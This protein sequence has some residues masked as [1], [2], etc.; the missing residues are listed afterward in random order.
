MCG[1]SVL[2]TFLVVLTYLAAYAVDPLILYMA[3]M[4][5]L[6]PKYNK[7]FLNIICC[8]GIFYLLIVCKQG[9]FL[10]SRSN[11]GGMI[12]PLL[13]GYLL[14][15][16]FTM[17]QAS[18][19]RIIAVVIS[20]YTLAFAVEAV[21]S[22][23]FVVVNVKMEQV[24][25]FGLKGALLTLIMRFTD[26][27][28][29]LFIKKF[30]EW[31]TEKGTKLYMIMAYSSL[32]TVAGVALTYYKGL[33]DT[34]MLFYLY[35]AQACIIIVCI[36]YFVIIFQNAID[37]E[38]E[39]IKKAELSE[40]KL[41]FLEYSKENYEEIRSIRHDMK[42]HYTYLLELNRRKDFQAIEN[43]LTELCSQL[44]V[45]DELYI[46]DNLILAVALSEAQ[47]KAKKVKI[48]FTKVVT[49]NEFPF[50]EIECNSLITNILDNAFEAAS[51]VTEGEKAV[52]LEI[53]RIN[54]QEIMIY[55]E[56]TYRAEAYE[57]VPFLST[58]KW[59][60]QNHGYGTKIIKKIVR[61]YK[62]SIVYWNDKQKF[63]V[64]IIVRDNKQNEDSYM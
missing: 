32:F 25:T 21:Y 31:I 26:L 5:Y 42:R 14:V 34:K 51:K 19:K 52:K 43:Y 48:N 28:V 11:I 46:C 38:Q 9:F 56:N 6:K 33:K 3:F 40:S 12:A 20:Y 7:K 49:V 63:Y 57:N 61:R 60:K 27:L 29:F 23:I 8:F 54:E 1:V 2:K 50:S 36:I 64:K 62:G 55:C 41:A 16:A 22:V 17:F 35:Y 4:T 13:F 59:D 18:A 39:L 58:V 15:I 53:R 30:Y 44:S 10:F 45:T 37:R 24:M 47:K